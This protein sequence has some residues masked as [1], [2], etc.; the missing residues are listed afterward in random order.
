MSPANP[1]SANIFVKVLAARFSRICIGLRTLALLFAAAS[2]SWVQ[3]AEAQTLKVLHSFTG[4]ADGSEPQAGVVRDSA[5]NF[6]G[7]TYEGGG[8]TC[9]AGCGVV[10]RLSRTGKFVVVHRFTGGTDGAHPVAGLILDARGNM[11]GTTSSGGDLSC[12]NGFGCGVVFKLDKT[13][14]EIVLHSFS[15]GSDGAGPQAG[16]VR[17][18]SGNLYGT[19]FSGGASN[20]GVIFNVDTAGHEAVLYSFNSST[21]GANPSADLVRD[22]AGNLYGT[23]WTGG[24]YSEGTVFKLDPL[25]NLTVLHNFGTFGDGIQP[26]GLIRDAAGN[27][28]GTTVQGGNSSYGVAYKLD[29]AGNETLLHTFS[30]ADGLNPDAA[31]VRDSAGNLYGTTLEGGI[32]FGT[33]FK[34]DSDGNET[35]LYSFT[36]G[37][38]GGL[39]RAGLILDP[40]G[41]LY[42]TTTTFGGSGTLFRLTP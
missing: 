40:A 33:V 20:S 16:L 9:I 10:F 3:F 18:T 4:G 29:A 37:S 30:G 21:D 5:G 35:V 17:G 39:P 27:L 34:L 28:Y 31:L 23:N 13:G 15:G 6:Y 32:G 2:I 12:G 8:G 24:K 14:N 19:T 25:G 11:Y 41:N 38:D 26:K 42:G 1:G 7:T 22:A 36:G